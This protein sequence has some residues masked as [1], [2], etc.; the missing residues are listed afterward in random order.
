MSPEGVIDKLLGNNTG[1]NPLRELRD[2]RHHCEMPRLHGIELCFFWWS[3]EHRGEDQAAGCG[4][5]NERQARFGGNDL[6]GMFD[7]CTFAEFGRVR[8][9]I[10]AANGDEEFTFRGCRRAEIAGQGLCHP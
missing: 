2:P 5:F 1:P 7:A 9:E 4:V 3:G 10:D 6:G 8:A